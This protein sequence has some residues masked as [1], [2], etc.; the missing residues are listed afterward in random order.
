MS[1]LL[2]LKSA[3]GFLVDDEAFLRS[4]ASSLVDMLR[5]GKTLYDQQTFVVL[6]AEKAW[7]LGFTSEAHALTAPSPYDKFVVLAYRR[8]KS[9]YSSAPVAANTEQTR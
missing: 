7:L 1:H 8:S 2:S 4:F 3:A 6:S 5:R 9:D